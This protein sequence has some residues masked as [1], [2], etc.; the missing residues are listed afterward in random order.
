MNL[1][2]ASWLVV[3]SIYAFFSMAWDKKKANKKAWRVSEKHFFVVA[4]IGGSLGV[5]FAMQYWRHKT[6]K[7]AFKGPIY[8]IIAVQILLLVALFAYWSM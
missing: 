7:W 3:I 1:I 2:I 4:A 6:Q 8:G 5:L